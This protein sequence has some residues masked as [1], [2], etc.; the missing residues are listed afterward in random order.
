MCLCKHFQ[1]ESNPGVGTGL[2]GGR[3]PLG[4]AQAAGNPGAPICSITPWAKGAHP[5]FLGVP[6]VGIKRLPRAAKSQRRPQPLPA[7]RF[8]TR[9]TKTLRIDECF[10]HLHRITKVRLP[11]VGS[12]SQASFKT[13]EARL[14]HWPGA[15]NTRNRA[16]CAT[17]CRRSL[18][19]RADQW[20]HWSRNLI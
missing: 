6:G 5:Q 12:R 17:K 11:I 9:A 13:R 1:S 4:S 8:V 18:T 10:H 16:F 20:S 15:A 3:G 7:S 14:G 2:A 19:W